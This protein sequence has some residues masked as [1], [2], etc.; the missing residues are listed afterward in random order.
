MSPLDATNASFIMS[1]IVLVSSRRDTVSQHG[2]GHNS[3]VTRLRYSANHNALDS[4]PI[5]PCL[6]SQ[7]DELCKNRRVS[8][9]R[10]NNNVQYVENNVFF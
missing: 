4:W 9:R 5:R 10:S 1:F 2:K 7:N 8:E 6:A 3:S